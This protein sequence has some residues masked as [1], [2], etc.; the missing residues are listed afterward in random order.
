MPQKQLEGIFT[1]CRECKHK[2]H[3]SELRE[4]PEKRIM[5]CKECY[6]EKTHFEEELQVYKKKEF[7]RQIKRLKYRCK[8]CD[9]KFLSNKDLNSHDV[10]PS[11]S[12]KNTL[13]KDV[14]SQD[15]LKKK[16]NY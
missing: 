11:C 8:W 2:I 4:H 13:Y 15:V 9:Y 7:L 14:K 12:K 6:G 5:V 10:C 1:I 3:I 16:F